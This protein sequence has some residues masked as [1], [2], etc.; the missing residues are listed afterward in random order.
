MEPQ[1]PFGEGMLCAL[2]LLL[3]RT[4]FRT[5]KARKGFSTPSAQCSTLKTAGT[6]RK[7]PLTSTYFLGII[8]ESKSICKKELMGDLPHVAGSPLQFLQ[9]WREIDA[10]HSTPESEQI[11]QSQHPGFPYKL[12]PSFNTSSVYV[13]AFHQTPSSQPP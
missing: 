1:G 5:Y 7:K 4:F 9:R 12:S 6:F 11:T 2:G 8:R 10:G 3:T 13:S